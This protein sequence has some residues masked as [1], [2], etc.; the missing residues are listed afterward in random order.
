MKKIINKY[1]NAV[2]RINW[3][4]LLPAFFPFSTSSGMVSV[5]LDFFSISN[6]AVACS[7]ISFYLS[8][9]NFLLFFSRRRAALY[10]FNPSVI[11]FVDKPTKALKPLSKIILKII[12]HH[13]INIS[14][15][16]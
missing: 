13:I 5:L 14:M 12:W 1:V 8:S 7:F 11:V 15:K 4:T 10:I 9:E 6:S 3:T 2:I 16:K